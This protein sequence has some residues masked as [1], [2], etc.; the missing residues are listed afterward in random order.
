MST[1]NAADI[2][3]DVDCVLNFP[4]KVFFTTLDMTLT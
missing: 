1:A 4:I 3:K 2:W